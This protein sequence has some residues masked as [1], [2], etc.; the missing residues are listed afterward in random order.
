MIQSPWAVIL[1]KF[2]DDSSATA[3]LEHYQRL[4][5][6]TGV[7]S[8]N[9]VDFFSDMSHGKLNLSHSTVFGWYTL[10]INRSAYAGN[11][12][13]PPPG[14]Y[15]RDGLVGLCIQAATAAGVN[16]ANFAGTLIS[17]NGHAD[18]FGYVGGMRAFCD[19]FSLIP[20][21]LGQEMGHGYGLDHSRREGSTLDY[22]DPWDVMSTA[23]AYE[24]PDTEYVDIGPGLN[25][26]NMRSRDWLD[27]TRVWRPHR[28]NFDT[29]VQLRPLHRRDLSGPLAA[30]LHGIAGPYLVEYRKKERWD[31]AIPRS[32][33]LVHRFY[34]NHSYLMTG[35]NGNSDLIAGDTFRDTENSL[36]GPFS[37]VEVVSIDDAQSTATVR[38]RHSLGISMP[39]GSS[40]GT[41][42][43]SAGVDGPG[44]IVVGGGFHPVPPWDPFSAVIA[45][46][47]S[48]M[49]LR[50]IGDASARLAAQRSA[51]NAITERLTAISS[52]LNPIRTPAIQA[53]ESTQK[54]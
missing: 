6:E 8:S 35:I 12:S 36:F 24:E 11:T 40:G 42:V 37:A 48:Y 15:N 49:E 26:W 20:S 16:L 43:G 39:T 45:Q 33:V 9:M 47:A 41:I 25:A 32:A 50:G 13:S 51:M 30:E 44:G 52:S 21:L 18:L 28:Y 3:P 46:L 7:G 14:Q 19:S 1:C 17:M 2:A 10:T 22:Q 31:A 4:F 29:T 38:L 53:K 27:E 5:T 23:N 54:K 34:D